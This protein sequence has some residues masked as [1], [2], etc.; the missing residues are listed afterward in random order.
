MDRSPTKFSPLLTQIL[1]HS[2]AQFQQHKWGQELGDKVAARYPAEDYNNMEDG[3]KPGHG[4]YWAS[5]R[6]WSDGMMTCPARKTAVDGA[7]VNENTFLYFVN[8]T[9]TE[10]PAAAHWVN[11]D[12]LGVFHGIDL[13]FVF[14]FTLALFGSEKT[15]ADQIGVFWSNFAKTG[16]VNS[17]EKSKVEWPKYTAEGDEALLIGGDDSFGI[18]KGLKKE[19]CDFWDGEVVGE[20]I[21]FGT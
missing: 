5:V 4:T 14:D 3:K 1:D 8:H 9:L 15:M 6:G 12:E 17:G 18:L 16:D 20:D 11:G 7:K 21:V 10:M 2:Y 19:F 13:V